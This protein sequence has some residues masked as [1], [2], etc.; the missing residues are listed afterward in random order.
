MLCRWSESYKFYPYL[1]YE[2]I[3]ILN[4]GKFYC[5][6]D[7]VLILLAITY[8]KNLLNYIKQYHLAKSSILYDYYIYIISIT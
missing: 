4:Q 1:V 2:G 8:V 6:A 7:E 3:P 5:I